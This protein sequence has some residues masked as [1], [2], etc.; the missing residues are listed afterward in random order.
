MAAEKL[1]PTERHRFE[2]DGD[3]IYEWDQQLE[4]V[5]MYIPLPDR[6]PTKLLYCTIKPK[7][8]ELGIKGNP[9]FLDHDL[10]GHVK[11]DCSFWTIGETSYPPLHRKPGPRNARDATETGERPTLAFSHSGTCFPRPTEVRAREAATDAGEV[12][13]R[14][15]RLRLLQCRVHRKRTRSKQIFRWYSTLIGSRPWV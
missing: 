13:R 5:N 8:L 6:L 15:S 12:S 11:T 1:A 7:H 4:E 14:A 9:P 10:A 3:L 2:Q